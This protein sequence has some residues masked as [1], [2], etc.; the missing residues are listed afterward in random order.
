MSLRPH[1]PP[2]LLLT[3]SLVLASCGGQ[4]AQTGDATPGGIA[5]TG[6]SALIGARSGDVQ[7][8]FEQPNAPAPYSSMVP[9]DPAQLRAPLPDTPEAQTSALAPQA[10]APT[11]TVRVYYSDP[12]PTSSPYRDGGSFHAI[13]LKNLLGQYDN[14]QVV[15][16]PISQYVAGD[17]ASSLRTFY[18][19]TVFDEKIPASFLQ[20]VTAGAPVSWIGY[21]IWEL[22]SSLGTLG[23]SYK[24]LHT[25]LTPTE[26]AAAYNTVQYKGY[27]YRKYPAQQEMIELGAD[28]ATTETLASAINSSGGRVP[29]LVRSSTTS[30]TTLSSTSPPPTATWCW[31]T[32]SIRCSATPRPPAPARSRRSCGWKT[33]RASTIPRP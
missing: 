23:L 9:I 5:T 12:L 18:I 33:F 7:P 21:N 2:A 27:N 11:R 24:G 1:T 16:K 4:T 17:A 15:S 13:M 29:Y 28:P 19:G 26:I 25:A 8:M 10:T 22:G 31:P 20:D 6:G 32:A 30:P 3:L 14:V